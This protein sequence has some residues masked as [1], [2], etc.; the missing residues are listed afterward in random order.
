MGGSNESPLLPESLAAKGV[1]GEEPK[2]KAPVPALGSVAPS[3]LDARTRPSAGRA[4]LPASTVGDG[5]A[6]DLGISHEAQSVLRPAVG[7]RAH[8]PTPPPAEP[9]FCPLK[10][11][12]E[13]LGT[14]D[15]LGLVSL[16]TSQTRVQID[17][18]ESRLRRMR[19]ATL[20]TGVEVQK[21]L[22]KPGFR[23]PQAV[24]ITLTYRPGVEWD[25]RHISAFCD[26]MQ[27]WANRRGIGKLKYCWVA[28]LQKRGAV[29]YHLIVWLPRGMMMPKPDKHGW[30]VHGMTQIERL[31]SGAAYAAKYASKGDDG[32]QFP[33]GLRLHGRGGLDQHEKLAV[34]WWCLSKWVREHFKEAVRDV[35][36][37]VGGYVSRL[38]GEFLA[39]PWRVEW[40]PGGVLYAVKLN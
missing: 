10:A 22:T 36:K 15:A 1:R 34:R 12:A 21:T 32:M 30:W 31:R 9:L 5:R 18:R 24:G 38:D 29:H 20:T 7:G 27:K 37:I 40:G 39:S 19:R 3:R 6:L 17:R 28:E 2:R 8:N 33:K 35:R 16:S 4:A 26:R 11:K 13:A 23:P 25:R 14:A